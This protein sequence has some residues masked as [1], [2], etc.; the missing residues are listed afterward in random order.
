MSVAWKCHL[1]A[2]SLSCDT[3]RLVLVVSFISSSPLISLAFTSQFRYFSHPRHAALAVIH[4]AA[5]AAPV[6]SAATCSPFSYYSSP[7]SP[8]CVIPVT[9]S[10][11]HPSS[12][13]LT[14]HPLSALSLCCHGFNASPLSSQSH[15]IPL[16][17]R[18]FIHFPRLSLEL[19]YRLSQSL[20]PKQ[21]TTCH[22]Q[23]PTSSP[24]FA[25]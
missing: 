21:C 4:A 14:L 12:S 8:R 22:F 17:S 20:L 25:S 24:L 1:H 16:S 3:C 18:L 7:P 19:F 13:L 11:F 5:A 15:L 23:K 10:C 6:S 2:S 9:P